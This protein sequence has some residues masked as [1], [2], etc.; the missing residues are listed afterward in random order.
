MRNLLH[1][2]PSRRLIKSGSFHYLIDRLPAY[3][4]GLRPVRRALVGA[5]ITAAGIIGAPNALAA[6]ATQAFG[7]RHYS[8]P[9]GPLGD[10]LATFARQAGV[11]LSIPPGVTAGKT[12]DGPSGDYSST[13]GLRQLIS[14]N[15][16]QVIPVADGAFRVDVAADRVPAS[17]ADQAM[18]GALAVLPA[19]VVTASAG[20]VAQHV[21]NAP[22]SISVITREDLESRPYRDLAD[23]LS[24]VPGVVTTGGSDRKEIP[25]AVWDRPT[26]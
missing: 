10:A 13:E 3:D 6:E 26:R 19:V 24:S 23:A 17:R 12:T 8:I 16:L 18:Q 2:A 20:G 7:S 5:T 22:A 21:K 1:H 9:A 25:F 15:G 4:R 11:T 14:Q